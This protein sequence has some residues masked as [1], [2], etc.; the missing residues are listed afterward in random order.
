M[1]KDPLHSHKLTKLI[2]T[3]NKCF[4]F[5]YSDAENFYV[6][7]SARRGNNR[8]YALEHSDATEDEQ[9][10]KGWRIEI[11]SIVATSLNLPGEHKDWKIASFPHNYSFV[12]SRTKTAEGKNKIQ[13]RLYAGSYSK[14]FNSPQE[15]VP[16]AIWLLSH[17]GQQKACQCKICNRSR[18]CLNV[19]NNDHGILTGTQS[20]TD[21][22]SSRP[23]IRRQLA[24]RSECLPG[25]PLVS[26]SVCRINDLAKLNSTSDYNHEG[27]RE[28]EV[29][30]L[31]L[32]TPIKYLDGGQSKQIDSWP[33][34]VREVGFIPQSIHQSAS[35]KESVCVKQHAQYTVTLLGSYET[36]IVGFDRLLPALANP[37][38]E[39]HFV[40]NIVTLQDV[41]SWMEGPKS[42]TLNIVNSK[43]RAADLRNII[44]AFISQM[45]ILHQKR[46]EVQLTD[47]FN[48]ESDWE[49]MDKSKMQDVN[50]PAYVEQEKNKKSVTFE[51]PVNAKESSF[52]A[53]NANYTNLDD[54]DDSSARRR[55]ETQREVISAAVENKGS[56][57]IDKN[58]YWAGM[59]L[60][61]ERVWVGDVVRL[62]LNESDIRHVIDILVEHNDLSNP[63][64]KSVP[65]LQSPV[66]LRIKAIFRTAEDS[67]VCIAGDLYR[68]V[69]KQD[70][71]RAF[72][73][74]NGRNAKLQGQTHLSNTIQNPSC[75][76]PRSHHQHQ[77]S[78]T[79]SL[80][81]PQST[82]QTAYFPR[83]V[84]Q[85]DSS[86]KGQ[87]PPSP[88]LP[89]A[90]G[91]QRINLSSV[92]I[93]VRP[94]HIAG[95]M[96]CSMV[97]SNSNDET[98]AK[99]VR[100]VRVLQHSSNRLQG[101]SV[102]KSD[103][104]QMCLAG[105]LPGFNLS[106]GIK[107]MQ[108]EDQKKADSFKH[109]A[110]IAVANL[111]QHLQ[112]VQSKNPDKLIPKRKLNETSSEDVDEC[113][114][115]SKSE[116]KDV[117]KREIVDDNKIDLKP[118]TDTD[119][120]TTYSSKSDNKGQHSGNQV[121][122]KPAQPREE[123]M[124]EE[125]FKIYDTAPPGFVT[126]INEELKRLFYVNPK[127]QESVWGRQFVRK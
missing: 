23:T 105:L 62:N 13:R 125:E 15:F 60:G 97:T 70:A 82:I 109:T 32:S 10:T 96:Y 52:A 54:E 100:Q 26:P 122:C 103:R 126:R 51:Q 61:F 75:S 113:A 28:G 63:M 77:S 55:G 20:A 84:S 16:H 64:D 6:P 107:Y 18:N 56:N 39:Q 65:N 2:D 116:Q 127:T 31:I 71:H 106:M 98:N 27:F 3:E 117:R 95:R 48:N 7:P 78:S 74:C 30:F 81:S 47:G 90:F 92:E 124:K 11:G 24:P 104:M 59:F 58:K 50:F 119:A 14:A 8:T 4:R 49:K 114:K 69:N 112:K 123:P 67:D 91:F 42:E 99:L 45:L 87:L 34:L 12:E 35:N 79:L 101:G 102:P 9:R 5:S 72:M 38:L 53:V 41:Q 121:D 33:V 118:K 22:N 111:N 120:S 76:T 36:V 1:F 83:C 29:V 44:C 19:V 86:K 94:R 108:P 43:P 115:K 73:E 46:K 21:T 85:L 80:E 17:E 37:L 40:Q 110:A 25:V 93:I 66:V 68:V 88:R 89:K 57:K